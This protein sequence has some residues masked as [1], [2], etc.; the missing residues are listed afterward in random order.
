MDRIRTDFSN[1]QFS[2][3]KEK[4]RPLYTVAPREKRKNKDQPDSG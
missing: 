3:R 4:T 1:P 2:D